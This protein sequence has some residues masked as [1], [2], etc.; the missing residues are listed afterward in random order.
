MLLDV[1]RP[2]L[3]GEKEEEGGSKEKRIKEEIEKENNNLLGFNLAS[4]TLFLYS[5]NFGSF[6]GL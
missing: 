2:K 5:G 6:V 1:L 3:D 4:R